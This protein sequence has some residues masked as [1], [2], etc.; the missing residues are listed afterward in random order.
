MNLFEKMDDPYAAA[1]GAY[2]LLRLKKFSEMRDWARNLASRFDFLADGCVIWAWQLIHQQQWNSQEIRKYLLMAVE[3]GLPV[4]SE[5]LRLLTDGLRLMGEDGR[6]PR[7]KVVQSAGV[8]LWSSPLTASLTAE[9]GVEPQRAGEA[10]ALDL[11]GH[12]RAVV[13]PAADLCREADEDAARRGA[14][15]LSGDGERRPGA[16][17]LRHAQLRGRELR[18]W[19]RGRRDGLPGAA[20][21]WRRR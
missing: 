13:G 15:D 10:A 9:P 17:H 8:V 6:A 4:Y 18:R 16:L 21:G 7:D 20:G 5:G 11:R 12:E 14:V 1:V 3:R 19:R 2:L